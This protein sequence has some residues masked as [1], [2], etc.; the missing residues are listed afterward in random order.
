L[1]RFNSTVGACLRAGENPSTQAGADARDR[2]ALDEGMVAVLE[3]ELHY[4][5]AAIGDE[6]EHAANKRDKKSAPA[7]LEYNARRLPLAIAVAR[8]V[9]AA[10]LDVIALMH[11]DEIAALVRESEQEWRD[12]LAGLRDELRT[13]I[14]SGDLSFGFSAAADARRKTMSAEQIRRAD[15]DEYHVQIR[16]YTRRLSECGRFLAAVDDWQAATRRVLAEAD[17]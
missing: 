2:F 11:L 15:M 1:T 10:E 8:G 13:Y 5:T 3:E 4:L 17:R 6:I 16:D 12:S 14:I 7:V 9:E